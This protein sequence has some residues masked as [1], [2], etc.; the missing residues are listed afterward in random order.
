MSAGTILFLAAAGIGVISGLRSLTTPAAVSWA[1]H[2]HWIDPA[3]TAMSFLAATTT[4]YGFSAMALL[5]LIS[6]KLPF[7]RPRTIP[8]AFA[9]RILTGA[10]SAGALYVCAHQPIY[11]GAVLGAVGAVAGTLGGYQ[12]RRRLVKALNIP[13]F[14]VALAEDAIAV[15]GAFFLVSRF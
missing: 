8:P 3:N 2:L 4:V 13:D 9:A 15:G 5:E 12:A 10:F 14:I 6:D 1:A 7:T 11:I